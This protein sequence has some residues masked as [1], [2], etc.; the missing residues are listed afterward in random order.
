M[1][2]I[3]DEIDLKIL[4]KFDF[5]YKKETLRSY[6]Y[7]VYSTKENEYINIHCCVWCHDRKISI[8]SA[9]EGLD[10]LFDLIQAGYVEKVEE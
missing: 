10:K 6:A 9:Y 4:E 5:K 1:L 3:K 8:H 2:K 7:Y